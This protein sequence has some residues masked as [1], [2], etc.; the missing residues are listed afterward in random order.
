MAVVVDLISLVAGAVEA[1]GA[2]EATEG[3]QERAAT[4][5]ERRAAQTQR[6]AEAQPTSISEPSEYEGLSNIL[7]EAQ[8]GTNGL[9]ESLDEIAEA[10]RDMR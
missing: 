9:I 4:E 1:A 6:D 3:E 7:T 5:G 10:I 2:A 8:Q